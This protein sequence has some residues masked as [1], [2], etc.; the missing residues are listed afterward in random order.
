[1]FIQCFFSEF[2]ENFFVHQEITS[3]LTRLQSQLNSFIRKC[4][5]QLEKFLV[6]H[7][8]HIHN[9]H[10]LMVEVKYMLSMMYG[11][12]IGYQFKGLT[13]HFSICNAIRSLT[14]PELP[15]QLLQRKIDICENVLRVYDAIDPG[16]ASQRTN[17]L[18]EL[19][20]ATIYQIKH[21][22]NQKRIDKTQATVCIVI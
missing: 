4:P 6:E 19:K 12:V 7:S 17:V 14:F 18:F 22:L 13:F 10:L 8:K 5:E 11:N 2:A 15:H 21:K 16:E 3:K 9:D 20:C 1:M